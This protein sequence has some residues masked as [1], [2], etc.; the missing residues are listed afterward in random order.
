MNRT[1][2]EAEVQQKAGQAIEA[3]AVNAKLLALDAV[4]EAARF[5]TSSTPARHIADTMRRLSRA[6]DAACGTTG[7][8]GPAQRAAALELAECLH[9]LVDDLQQLGGEKASGDAAPRIEA[10][11]QYSEALRTTATPEEH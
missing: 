9:A 2:R 11:R 1:Y 5:G 3:C 10:L 4:F 7:N 6:A 8:R